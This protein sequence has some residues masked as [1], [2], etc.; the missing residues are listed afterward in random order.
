MIYR[1]PII[2]LALAISWTARA[3]ENLPHFVQDLVERYKQMPPRSS[4][5]AV[6]RYQYEGR[7]VYFVPRLPCCDIPSALYT[8]SGE[9][10]CHPDGGFTGL[11]D[12][13]C[14]DF[15]GKRT[16]ERLVWRDARGTPEPSEPVRVRP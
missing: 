3:S 16:S 12:G 15:F 13:T 8:A 14:L 11:G 10:L 9:L 7:V 5:G 4:P 2:I 1:I 6:W